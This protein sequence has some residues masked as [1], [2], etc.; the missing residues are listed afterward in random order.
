MVWTMKEAYLKYKGTGIS[1]PLK[2]F[3]VKPY[4]NVVVGEKI[5]C[6]TLVIGEYVYAICV[7]EDVEISMSIE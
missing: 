5:G 3:H 2:S 6:K 7:D 1:I 4:E